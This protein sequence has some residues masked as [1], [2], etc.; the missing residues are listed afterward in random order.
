MSV[1]RAEQEILEFFQT[2]FK[3][4]LGVTIINMCG[5]K[6]LFIEC[7]KGY[8][9][10]KRTSNFSEP[11]MVKRKT[12]KGDVTLAFDEIWTPS[13]TATEWVKKLISSL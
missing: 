2:A 6:E 7:K 3:D 8:F 11:P 12:K 10:V 5:N 13:T 9:T 1:S 4:E